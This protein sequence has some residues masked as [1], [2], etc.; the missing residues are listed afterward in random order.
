MRPGA[1]A[2]R[3]SVFLYAGKELVAVESVNSPADHM[4][5]RKLIDSG[6]ELTPQQAG[7]PAFDLKALISA[8]G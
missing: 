6:I 1:D 4:A 3:F 8:R 2:R 5:A 7:D